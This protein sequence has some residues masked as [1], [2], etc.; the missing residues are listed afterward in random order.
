MAVW[1]PLKSKPTMQFPIQD[2]LIIR[3]QN[4][5]LKKKKKKVQCIDIAEGKE[6]A[7]STKSIS[8]YPWVIMSKC[9]ENLIG[10]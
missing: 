4:S 9:F 10:S 7:T 8:P 2:A 5:G 1:T 6:V 3:K